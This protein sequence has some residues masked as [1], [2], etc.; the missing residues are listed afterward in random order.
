LRAV[1]IWSRL[2]GFVSLEIGGNFAGMGIDA[3]SLFEIEIES[4]AP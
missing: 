1:V 3:A 4:L 2:H